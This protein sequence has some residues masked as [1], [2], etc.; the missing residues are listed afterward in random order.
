MKVNLDD[1]PV[2]LDTQPVQQADPDPVDP[3]VDDT[4]PTDL[5]GDV[6]NDEV[7][8]DEVRDLLE[9]RFKGDPAKLAKSFKSLEGMSGRNGQQAGTYRK[10]LEGLGYTF[11]EKGTPVPPVV[12][13]PEPVQPQPVKPAETRNAEGYL[14]DPGLGVFTDSRTGNTYNPAEDVAAP[15]GGVQHVW[16]DKYGIAQVS[17]EAWSA[18]AD[19]DPGQYPIVRARYETDKAIKIDAYNRRMHEQSITA[20]PAAR[21]RFK[22]EADAVPY[23]KDDPHVKAALDEAEQDYLSLPVDQRAQPGMFDIIA[24][25]KLIK[26]MPDLIKAATERAVAATQATLDG[27]PRIIGVQPGGRS[28]GTRVDDNQGEL[29]AD[30]NAMRKKFEKD[31][32]RAISV[33]EWKQYGGN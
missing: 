2:I 32:G 23:M 3:V 8:Y 13:Q 33:K 12:K 31:W 30:E 28:T 20:M 16:R 21:Q 6:D 18:Y 24:G 10:Q 14:Y 7:D 4:D 27:A 26:R 25:M 15:G 19:Q 22:A 29:P 9:N 5:S 1:E 11:D 17:E